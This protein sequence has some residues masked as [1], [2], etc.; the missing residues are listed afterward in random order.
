[1][2][3]VGLVAHDQKKPLLVAWAERHRAALAG[4]V[5]GT[6]AGITG[7]IAHC[8]EALVLGAQDSTAVCEALMRG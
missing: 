8:A 4:Y 2:H 6:A 3:H 5:E 1:M 7:W